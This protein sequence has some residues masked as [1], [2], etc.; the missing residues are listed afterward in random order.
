[1]CYKVKSTRDICGPVNRFCCL[2]Q[3]FEQGLQTTIFCKI[4]VLRS[5]KFHIIF[6][7]LRKAKISR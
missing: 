2:L 3:S 7:S 1:M 5:K 4:S 6:Y